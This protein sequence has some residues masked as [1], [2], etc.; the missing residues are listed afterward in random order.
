MLSNAVILFSSINDTISVDLSE[1][2]A[3]VKLVAFMFLI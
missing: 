1:V 2:K 3:K